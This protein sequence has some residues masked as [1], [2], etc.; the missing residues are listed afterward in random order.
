MESAF[1][2]RLAGACELSR[3]SLGQAGWRGQS[4]WASLEEGMAAGLA[5]SKTDPPLGQWL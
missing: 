4:D 5:A 1:G 3:R 2:H